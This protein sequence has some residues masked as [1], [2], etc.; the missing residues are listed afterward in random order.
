MATLYNVLVSAARH[1][2]RDVLKIGSHVAWE[3]ASHICSLLPGVALV[4][5]LRLASVWLHFG[6]TLASVWLQFGFTLASVW[7]RVSFA[8]HRLGLPWAS[9]KPHLGFSMPLECAWTH[10]SIV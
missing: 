10:S 9:T 1:V 3:L 5:S 2:L 8:E 6:F 7:L 4:M